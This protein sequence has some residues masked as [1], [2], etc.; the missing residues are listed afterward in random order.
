MPIASPTAIPAGSM[1][2]TIIRS[3][4]TSAT[5]SRTS[6]ATSVPAAVAINSAACCS[7][8]SSVFGPGARR[9]PITSNPALTDASRVADEARTDTAL[10]RSASSLPAAMSGGRFPPLAQLTIRT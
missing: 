9:Y 7:K 6:R 4:C 8:A 1:Q 3:G 5:T 2:S 10:S